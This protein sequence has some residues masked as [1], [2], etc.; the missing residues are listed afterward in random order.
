MQT[1]TQMTAA[2][3]TGFGGPEALV[4]RTDVPVPQ[5]R[6]AEVLIEV[7]AAGVNNTDIWTREGAYG[8]PGDSH[9]VAGWKGVDLDFPRIQGADIA[10][11]IV[12][13]GSSVEPSRL[14]ER[15]IV[16]PGIFELDNGESQLV[17][18]I[19]S[20]RDGG[21]ADYAVVPA[22]HAHDVTNSPLDDNQLACLPIAYG[23]AMGMLERAE[24]RAGEQILV[25][26]ASG[27]L[28]SALVQL[29]VA[30]GAVVTGLTSSRHVASVLEA[31]A[32]DTIVRDEQ[33]SSDWLSESAGSR[34]DV[35]A[36]VVGDGVFEAALPALR[37]GGRLVTAG[38]IAGPVV[39]LDLRLLYLRQRR[40]IGST[41]HT[42]AHFL[43]LVRLA[44]EGSVTPHVAATYPLT[45]IHRAQ[46]RFL[47]KDVVGRIVIV[48]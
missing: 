11:R 1:T 27:A 31:G 13:V 42:P 24:V 6:E 28:G 39:K 10:G 34:F 37:T 35:I 38:A 9:A 46:E 15:V 16:D 29:A 48:P 23:T 12:A 36:D 47:A 3:L 45:E 41:M 43:R 14:G 7:A 19:G 17:E 40:L 26:G 5:P 22:S 32:H 8:T 30:R 33:G 2:L 44:R 20:E 25:T 4:V 21:F 18:V